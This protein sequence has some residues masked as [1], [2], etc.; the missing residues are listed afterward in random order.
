MPARSLNSRQWLA[1]RAYLALRLRLLGR[2]LREI[3]WL[4]LALIGPMLLLMLLQ[5]LV[6]LS[7]HPAGRWLVPL[8]VG[9]TVAAAHRQRADASFLASVAPDCRPWLA[10]EYGLLVLP[11]VLGLLALRAPGSAT[12]TLL[13]A[14]LAAWL[15]AAH[16]GVATRHRWRSPFRSEAFEWVGGMRATKGLLLWPVLVGLAVWQRAL[17]VVP[18]AAL[19]V[20]LLVVL[21]CYGEP[22]PVT[23]LAVA[24]RT[25]EQFLRRRLVLGLGYAAATALPFWLLLGLGRAGWGGAI[26][27]A[28]FWL[29]LVSMV[30]MAKYSFY[31]NA[32]HLRTTQSLV[33][34]LALLGAMHPAYPPLLL[35]ALGGLRWQS[36]R[37]VRATLGEEGI[38]KQGDAGEAIPASPTK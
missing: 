20:W 24:A 28:V 5:A 33:V 36:L 8:L 3:G 1:S 21:A 15:P 25:P 22:E 4:R 31:P 27:T 16:G 7:G 29:L 13:L 32:T 30:I 38:A 9:A 11:V 19:V 37:R 6:V 17:P 35:V 10:L 2:L 23:M 14:A 18:L 26:A 12:L 34:G